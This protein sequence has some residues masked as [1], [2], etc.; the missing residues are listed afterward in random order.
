MDKLQYYFPYLNA[1]ALS[2]DIS[3]P[4]RTYVHVHSTCNVMS[5]LSDWKRAHMCTENHVCFGQL[6][7]GGYTAAS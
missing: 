5:Q 4:V 1:W 3:V 7:L 2:E 6:D